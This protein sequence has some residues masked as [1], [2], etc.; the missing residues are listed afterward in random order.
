[1]VSPNEKQVFVGS[2]TGWVGALDASTGEVLWRKELPS[3][4][5]PR[6]LSDLLYFEEAHA[7]VVSSWGGRFHALDPTSG[8]EKFTWDA[9]VS[10]Y[11]AA[12]AG[13]Q[14]PL[15][16][17]RVA[18]ERGTELVRITSAGEETV[19]HRSPETT[20]GARRT[21]VAAAPVLDGEHERL[22][23]IVN[24]DQACLVHAWSIQLGQLIWSRDLPACVQATPALRSDGTLVIADLAGVV[25]G[26]GADGV[27]KFR[28]SSGTEFLLAAPVIE[29][30][31]TSFIADPVGVLHAIAIDGRGERL[32]E[33]PR[34][35]QGRASFAPSGSLHLPCT[36]GSVYVFNGKL[37]SA[38]G[39]R[40]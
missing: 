9:G 11:S 29:A 32:Y 8:T 4:S 27:G 19:V 23:F 40:S 33:A 37:K 25:H 36:D 17:L 26:I 21:L 10:P 24:C 34:A 35:F 28:Y 20:R 16:C 38:Q 3:H 2:H 5:D 15:Y 12:T 39:T 31:G 22:F 1:V 6:I 14:G 13:S 7:I 18:A 30:G